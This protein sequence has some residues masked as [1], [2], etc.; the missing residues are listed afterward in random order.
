MKI[1][2]MVCVITVIFLSVTYITIRHGY[3]SL[4]V[5]RI[6][7]VTDGLWR[8][9][10]DAI[11]V[12]KKEILE[13]TSEEFD[14]KFPTDLT[15]DGNWKVT[16]INQAIDSLLSNKNVDIVIALGYLA[17]N[18]VCKR[19]ELIKP[20]IAP[21]IIDA[22]IQKLPMK[23]DAS[24]IDN[25]NYIN[26]FRGVGRNIQSFREVAS[27]N[28]LTLLIDDLILQ[29]I[30]ELRKR[31][32]RI[33]NEYNVDLHLLTMQVSVEETLK[34]LPSSTEAV[35]VSSLLRINLN[36]FKKLATGLI[37]LKL[38][39]FSFQGIEDVKL[40]ILATM[41]PESTL[42]NLARSVAINA[43]EILHGENAGS[44]NVAFTIGEQLTI[45]MATA[46]AIDI[47]PSLSIL[48]EANLINEE[49][50][51]IQRVL[52]IEKSVQ[53]ALSANLDLSAADKFIS[54]GKQQV[55]RARSQL[56]PQIDLSSNAVI[57]DDDRAEASGGSYP[58]KTWTGSTTGTQLLYSEKAWSDYTVQ[59]HFQNS[60]IEERETLKLDIIQEAA[61]SYLN[62]L[63]TKIIERILKDNLKLTRANLERARVRETVGIA[64]PDEVYRWE[65][66]IAHNRQ[67]VLEAESR[68]LDAMNAL[69]RILH[70]PLQE[71]FITDKAE[72][73]KL[74]VLV[75]DKLY[76]HLVKNPKKLHT[77][78]D[79]MIKEGL[80]I[81]PELSRLDA[82][83][84]ARK[85]IMVSAKRAYWLPSVSLQS[86]VSELFSEDGAGTS[87]QG[88][89]RL[90][91]EK[92]DT[93]WN[94]GVFATFPLFSG[95][96]K[97]AT[98]RQ[99]R[100]DLARLR[101]EYNATEERIEQ[102]ILNTINL[103]RASYPGIQLSRDAADSAHKNLKL[104][105]DSYVRGI[106][107]I[108][109]LLDAQNL[110]LVADQRAANA[111]FDF[112]TDLTRVQRSVGKFD[113]FL[114]TED[115]EIWFQK[116]EE[117]FK[118]AGINL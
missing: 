66:S 27:F 82:E 98:L 67:S 46:R 45:N 64:G 51:D 92:N 109:D 49:R 50:K 33:A 2:L 23:G 60:R 75:S 93:D 12:F 111:V 26:I 63:R 110:A 4:P 18:E 68:S 39:S 42:Q 76:F 86:E 37:K 47:Y 65:S 115:Q 6:G 55:K 44:L 103:T 41:T 59:K 78:R 118:K 3:G 74:L 53:E 104:I 116:L 106:K 52:T 48:T 99:A 30:P 79:F 15:L 16:G 94:I 56:L 9:Y 34:N 29:A 17:S 105:T 31:A 61:T 13:L 89:M 102:R 113:L 58:E 108:I 87:P 107:S 80:K 43:Y 72:L 22:K 10:P 70:R 35:L 38:P 20:V 1:R 57:I 100:E 91:P 97:N 28:H 69:N 36:D 83:I 96:E 19:R 62:V 112:F 21:C 84:A 25:L 54:A 114:G 81:A 95:G 90:I 24:G 40:G 7:I 14:V 88:L 5:V 8:V 85:R 101:I 117:F 11:N 77:F 71:Q 73:D 32:I